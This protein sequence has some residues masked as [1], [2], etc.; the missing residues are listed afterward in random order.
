ML[1][2]WPG[3]VGA[4]ELAFFSPGILP[5]SKKKAD[6]VG[7]LHTLHFISV[8]MGQDPR[9]DINILEVLFSLSGFVIRVMCF[10]IYGF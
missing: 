10:D 4:P 3:S 5:S 7:P 9:H 8:S 6:R 1:I 2:T